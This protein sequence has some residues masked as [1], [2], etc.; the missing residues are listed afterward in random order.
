MMMIE[1]TERKIPHSSSE[2]Q[3]SKSKYVQNNNSWVVTKI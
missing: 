1:T 2:W 3:K